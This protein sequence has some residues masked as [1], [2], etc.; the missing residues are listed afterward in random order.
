M[1]SCV[2]FIVMSNC[3]STYGLLRVVAE[4]VYFSSSVIDHKAFFVVFMISVIGT[5]LATLCSASITWLMGVDMESSMKLS[6]SAHKAREGL[7]QRKQSFAELLGYEEMLRGSA[8][9]DFDEYDCSTPQ[10]GTLNFS[11]LLLNTEDTQDSTGRISR[12]LCACVLIYD[13]IGFDVCILWGTFA[14]RG[15]ATLCGQFAAINSV[16]YVLSCYA[17]AALTILLL[18]RF[19][20]LY[21]P[22][23]AERRCRFTSSWEAHS[24]E[25]LL[26]GG[27]EGEEL[28]TCSGST[29][30]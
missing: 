5:G 28:Q 17:Y 1:Y 21:F 27:E 19:C 30:A 6:R 24:A 8:D 22:S 12:S 13:V 10:A 2:V 23:A 4:L 9:G 7:V 26:P 16:L 18:S 3:D 15:Y 29:C 14:V 11:T 25:Q 20:F